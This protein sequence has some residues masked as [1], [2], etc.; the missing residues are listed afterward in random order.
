MNFT[1]RFCAIT[2]STPVKRVIRCLLVL[3]FFLLTH[4]C[5]SAQQF[6]PKWVDD[7]GGAKGNTNGFCQVTDITTDKENNVYITGAFNSD[8]VDFDP[9]PGVKLL[10]SDGNDDAFVGKY[11]ADGTLIWVESFSSVSFTLS[12]TGT[13][14]PSAIAVDKDGNVT[15]TG[16]FEGETLDTD[17]GP[18][19][20][21]L[22]SS[23]EEGLIIHLD[24]N[25]NFLWA[26]D[27]GNY[28]I[29]GSEQ[30]ATD[31]QDNVITTSTFSQTT[32]IGDSTYTSPNG[33]DAGLIIKY[34]PTGSVL[35]SVCL[36]NNDAEINQRIDG[37]RVDSK[38]N[39][40]VSGLFNYTI[41]FNPL[42]GAFNVAAPNRRESFIAKYSPAGIIAWVDTVNTNESVINEV[43]H[44]IIGIDQQDNIYFD[45]GFLG[46]AT[47]NGS[48]TLNAQGEE[49][50]CFAKYAPSGQFIF[51]KSIGGP[52]SAIVNNYKILSD[53]DNN[54]YLAGSFIQTVNFNPNPG[55][56]QN[57]QNPGGGTQSFVAEYDA[58]GNYIYAF[59][60]GSSA[61]GYT[62]AFGLAVDGNGNIDAC[63]QFCSTVNFDPTGCSSFNVTALG[64]RADGYFVQYAPVTLTNNIITAPAVSHFCTS[65]TPGA[66]T[67]S[68]PLGGVGGYTYQWQNS[69]DSVSFANIPGADSINY[70]PPALTTTTYY[71]RTV[72]QTCATPITSNIIGIYI[73]SPPAAPQVPGDTICAGVTTKLSV[74]SPQQG[75]TYTWYADATGGSTLFTGASFTTP[76]LNAT[77]I[78]YA[79]AA[80]TSCSSITRTA[81]A[82][83]VLQPLVAPLVTV[84]TVTG[85]SVTFDWAPVP[86]ATGYQVSTDS[87]KTFLAPASGVDGLTTTVT[88]L[89]PGDSVSL[90]V[91]A[92]GT[93]P[94]QLSAASAPVTASIPKND[95]IYV[96][97]AFTPNGDGRN[98]Q[99]HVHGESIQSLRFSIYDQ[100]G[101]LLFTSNNTQNGWNGT[102]RGTKEPAGVYVY[103]LEAM[104][105]DGRSINKKGTITLLR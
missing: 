67:G 16:Y 3:T 25:G 70:I 99:V 7:L 76:A 23:G 42:G 40:I 104:M 88:G 20:H 29:E 102:F 27:T 41:N 93:T 79:E 77:T 68:T 54:I 84:G 64:G 17:P 32:V 37:C 57:I 51:A 9:G 38:D 22:T 80:N 19:V 81:V 66:I 101:E 12:S 96:P 98:D 31:S 58:G 63:G 73:G 35:W 62:A 59:S 85:T 71:R 8:T 72:S 24:T 14:R 13:A 92:I 91:E 47:F 69:A 90:I 61:C 21:N 82:V 83:T 97:N 100:W 6:R 60:S 74:T 55:D 103:Y 87:G 56:P 52:A 86:G 78:Y 18:G 48:V 4:F 26:F 89:Q 30:V 50:L 75:L 39:I 28:S 11:K 5:A 36:H 105:I 53:K 65:G 34:S 1:K 33:T 45:S 95:I 15:I 44:S 46:F 94:C 49:D 2:G 10:Q 43:Y